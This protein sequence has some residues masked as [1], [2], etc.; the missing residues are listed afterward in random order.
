MH[1]RKMEEYNRQA[2]EF[3]F[4]EN[5]APD[6]VPPDTIDLH[7]LYV[8]EAEDVLEKRIKYAQQQGQP[9]LHV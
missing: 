6:R 7:G 1:G 9:H 5:N 8:E 3:I 4:R 2:S